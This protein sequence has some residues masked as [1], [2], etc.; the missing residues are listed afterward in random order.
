MA[1]SRQF[2]SDVIGALILAAAIHTLFCIQVFMALPGGMCIYALGELLFFPHYILMFFFPPEYPIHDNGVVD[3]GEVWGK[4]AVAFPASL[5][6]GI[7]IVAGLAL[8][9]QILRRPK[10][11]A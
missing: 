4:L 1:I 3:Y 2:R 6:Y 8:F 7:V 5:A 10:H 11:D 9:K